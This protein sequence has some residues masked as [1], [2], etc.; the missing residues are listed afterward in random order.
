[1]AKRRRGAGEGSIFR[2]AD[3][4]WVGTVQ[5]GVDENGKRR[6]RTVYGRTR[7]D[8]LRK[9]DE[10][11][12]QIAQGTIPETSTLKLGQYLDRWLSDTASP[13]VRA[14]TLR[15]YD[16]MVRVHIKRHVG[17]VRLAS[18]SPLHV[19]GLH[20]ALGEAGASPRCVQQAHTVLHVALSD[21]VRLGLIARNVCDAVSRPRAPRHEIVHLD[22]DQVRRLFEAA[23]GDRFEALY[24]LAVTS[25]MRLGELLGLA[26]RDVD[27]ESR[28]VEVR[29]SLSEHGSDLWLEEP[30]TAKS[31][32]RIDLP[33]IAVAALRKHRA[34]LGA[35]PHGERLVFTDS[36]GGPVRRSNLERRSF[37]PLLR[38]A[39]L[40]NVTFHALRHTAA[41]LMLR[42]GIHP[43]VVQERLGHS[44][45]ALTLDTYSHAVPTLQRD[46][47]DRLDTLLG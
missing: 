7:T 3:G 9:V 28:T 44:Q 36:C 14:S 31:R 45:I 2:R 30:K 27:L 16:R 39:E 17:G 20:R 12:Q 18:L 32:R 13:R 47:A 19:Q 5:V 35:V 4:R 46:A 33:R 29:R 21:A 23:Q 38:R 34:R 15:H 40:P 37:K 1:M 41:T 25:G 10:I 26:W 11:R 24:V 22:Q 43:K 42:A 8:V 6:R